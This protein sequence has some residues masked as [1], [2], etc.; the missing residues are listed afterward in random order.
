MLY[1]NSCYIDVCYNEVDL[2][3]ELNIQ[4]KFIK[5]WNILESVKFCEKEIKIMIGEIL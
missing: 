1:P 5:I 3:K 2:Y 4:V